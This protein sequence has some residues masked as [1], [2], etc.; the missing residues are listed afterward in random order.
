MAIRINIVRKTGVA[1][2]DTVEFRPAEIHVP[3]EERVFW[4]NLDPLDAH[5]I[6]Q[7]P[8]DPKYI[9]RPYIG[10][11]PAMT[12]MFLVTADVVYSC[13]LHPTENGAITVSET[14]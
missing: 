9:L 10:E 8:D 1:G 6:D 3:R 12:P 13:R 2:A 4:C 5:Q 7:F 11:P 14:S